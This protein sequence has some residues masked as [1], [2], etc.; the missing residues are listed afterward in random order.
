M[1]IK[2]RTIKIIAHLFMYELVHDVEDGN[3]D[4][5]TA[6]RRDAEHSQ[7]RTLQLTLDSNIQY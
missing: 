1:P 2:I 5:T 3:E 7:V 4:C 6:R